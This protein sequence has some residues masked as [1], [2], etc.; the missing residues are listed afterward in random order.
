MEAV[1][2]ALAIQAGLDQ[3]QDCIPRK[4]KSFGKESFDEPKARSFVHKG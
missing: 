4:L 2:P 3:F 1:L